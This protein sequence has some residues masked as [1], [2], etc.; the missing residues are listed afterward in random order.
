[1]VVLTGVRWMY[2]QGWDGW[3]GRAGDGC[4]G[5]GGTDIMQGWGGLE[6]RLGTAPAH[7]EQPCFWS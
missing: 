4:S 3:T 1:M 5:R 7:Y 6:C 2:W